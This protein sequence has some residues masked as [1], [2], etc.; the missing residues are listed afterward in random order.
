MRI[1]RDPRDVGRGKGIPL[2][3][4]LVDTVTVD[5]AGGGTK[6]ELRRRLG[7]DGAHAD[8]PAPATGGTAD[9]GP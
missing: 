7:Q 8:E 1:G 9:L 4:G 2:M 3:N 5:G 6:V